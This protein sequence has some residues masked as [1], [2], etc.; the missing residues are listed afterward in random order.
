MLPSCHLDPTTVNDATP[1]A[2]PGHLYEWQGG[3][4]RYVQ[5]KDSVTYV[6]GHTLLAAATDLTAATN[7]TS[8]GSALGLKCIGIAQAV[9]TTDYYGYIMVSGVCDVIGDGSVAAG[10]FVIQGTDGVADTMADGEE[11]QVFGMALEDDDSNVIF[12]CAVS[13]L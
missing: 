10:E 11:E 12:A 5:L 8:G 3:I 13:C 9:Y 6:K 4:Y 2:T 1:K 7:D